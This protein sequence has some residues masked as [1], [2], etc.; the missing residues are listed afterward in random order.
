MN[1]RYIMITCFMAVG[2]ALF[3][4]NDYAATYNQEAVGDTVVSTH[5]Y[6]M[7]YF[8]DEQGIKN[9]TDTTK[10]KNLA[11]SLDRFNAFEYIM[12]TRYRTYG[13]SFS[14]KWSDHLF[15]EVGAGF[16]R[17]DAPDENYEFGTMTVLHGSIGKQFNKYHTLRGTLIGGWA[18]QKKTDVRFLKAG[19]KLDHI[20]DW[21]SYI[22]GYNPTRMMSV[23]SVIGIGTQYSHLGRMQGNTMCYEGHAGVQ[24]KF[25]TG[26]YGAVT[27]EPYAGLGTDLYDLSANSS[28]RSQNWRDFDLFY[29]FSI[30]YVYY[31]NNNLSKESR[32][33]LIENRAET[34]PLFL[35][36]GDSVYLASRNMDK[37]SKKTTLRSWS[38]PWFFEFTNGFSVLNSRNFQ[39]LK[40]LGSEVTIS[41]GKWLSPVI[42]LRLSTVSRESTWKTIKTPA[43]ETPYYTPEYKEKQR[44]TYAGFRL[45]A[46]FNPF[47][48]KKDFS[49]DSKFGG[50]LLLGG[51]MGWIH[52]YKYQGVKR[53]SCESQTYTAGINAW[54]KLTD[55][56]QAFVEPRLIRYE[57]KLHYRG[58]VMDE[59][60]AGHEGTINVGLRV[61]TV[62]KKFRTWEP[63][64][65]YI[66]LPIS[67][68]GS[69]GTNFTQTTSSYKGGH[70]WN[71]NLQLFAQ[72]Q[73]NAVSGVRLAYERVSMA[74]S[75]MG[76][77][78][79]YSKN[80][81]GKLKY[82]GSRKGLFNNRYN[83]NLVSFDYNIN[84][85]NAFAGYDIMRNIE[86]E[87]FVGPTIAM[88][89]GA[90]QELDG[91]ERV[92]QGYE[93]RY[94]KDFGKSQTKIGLN[95]GLKLKYNLNDNMSVFFSPTL[96]WI[97]DMNVSRRNFLY[98]K[99]FETLNVGMQYNFNVEKIANLLKK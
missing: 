6:P 55:G 19:I 15:L 45:E 12:D 93:A 69:L 8:E 56:L 7:G 13:E 3:A 30:G 74:N 14:K 1:M 47:G 98:V 83:F 23:S 97:G 25:Y 42:G 65:V 53:L 70:G 63:K 79:L 90:T 17:I 10:K 38:K 4:A 32:M 51:E 5:D 81:A 39:Y 2:S 18:Y 92:E 76:S 48:F 84:L 22:S 64:A 73:F 59:H 71:Y 60:I 40:T 41:A 72:Y 62:A 44:Q 20:F 24:L 52:R 33:S 46:M 9:L 95:G 29:G 31:L 21:S 43:K 26:P 96:Y 82:E 58:A 68:G 54:M 75:S 28:K 77:Y 78:S 50:H 80:D 37:L 66:D 34:D 91:D 87:A 94:S 85:T 11:D 61:S 16:Q 89:K 36:P 99:Y 67:V 86:L 88:Y 35:A 49:W 27:F 57:Y